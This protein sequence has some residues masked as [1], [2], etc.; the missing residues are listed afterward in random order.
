MAHGT[1]GNKRAG[2]NG[3]KTRMERLTKRYEKYEDAPGLKNY[4]KSKKIAAK[5]DKIVEKKF[6]KYQK[7][8]GT[9][10][11]SKAYTKFSD[12]RDQSIWGG[13]Y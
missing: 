12:A 13:Y 9:K 10:G 8:K 4:K 1:Y 6:D 7:K 5:Q 2:T 11:Q 3:S